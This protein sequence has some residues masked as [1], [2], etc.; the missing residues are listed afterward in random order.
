MQQ[1]KHCLKI[2]NKNP[3]NFTM[4]NVRYEKPHSHTNG[5]ASVTP[6]KP[7]SGG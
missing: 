4:Y 3:Y 6:R 7:R 5:I 1:L 2:D